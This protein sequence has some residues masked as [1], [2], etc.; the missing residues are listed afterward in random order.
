MDVWY[1]AIRENE[2]FYPFPQNNNWS[3]LDLYS[4]IYPEPLWLN[5]TWHIRVEESR[6]KE[7]MHRRAVV[8]D[9]QSLYCES[10]LLYHHLFFPKK[11][12]LRPTT[13]STA[14]TST[15]TSTRESEG[16]AFTYK[17][18]MPKSFWFFAT[19][20]PMLYLIGRNILTNR[21]LSESFKLTRKTTRSLIS[22]SIINSNDII[23]SN[24]DITNSRNASSKVEENQST[25][26][27]TTMAPISSTLALGAGYVCGLHI[28]CRIV[29]CLALFTQHSIGIYSDHIMMG[30]LLFVLTVILLSCDYIY[31]N[32]LDIPPK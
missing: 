31:Y 23:N 5:W 8:L 14:N 11:A 32:G 21:N 19:S 17:I 29:S 12:D 2:I 25:G 24:N 27:T 9:T 4:F 15:E 20:F 26:T 22:Q 7:W 3:P 1:L 16:K 28:C 30:L 10:L 18:M 13:H 6:A